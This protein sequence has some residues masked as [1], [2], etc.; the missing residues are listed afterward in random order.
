MPRKKKDFS[1]D[2]A[3]SESQEDKIKLYPKSRES[4]RKALTETT[5]IEEPSDYTEH[6]PGEDTVFVSMPA[7]SGSPVSKP[8]VKTKL[9]NSSLRG[10]KTPEDSTSHDSNS[11]L[12]STRQPYHSGSSVDDFWWRHPK[13]KQNWKV[14][15]ASLLL[16]LLGSGLLLTGIIAYSHPELAGI[17][18]FVFFIA[19]FICFLPGAYHVGYVYLAVKGK[20]GFDFHHLPLFN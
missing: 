1:I 4:E 20:R 2:D 15:A 9:L 17:Q 8:I 11:L 13:V 14:V 18:G 5:I 7:H 6:S 10:L 12:P 19:G 16:I 3:F